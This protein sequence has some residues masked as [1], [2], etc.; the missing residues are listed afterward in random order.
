MIFR[1]ASYNHPDNE[2]MVTFFGASTIYNARGR[3]QLLRKRMVIEGEI[4]AA[5]PTAISDRMVE[6]NDAYIVSG[7][8]ALLLS[9][10]G[11][12]AYSLPSSGSISGVRVVQPP[13]FI[14]QEGKAHMATGLPFSVVLE[15]DYQINDGD[16][17]VS[18]EETITH[19]G[20]GGPRRV[21]LELDSGQPIEQIV[22]SFTPVTV[23]QA[24]EA[25]GS[26]SYPNVNQ[27]IFPS[28]VDLPDGL[29]IS[30]SAPRLDGNTYVDWPIRWAYRMALTSL[31]TIP[32]PLLR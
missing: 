9:D 28:Q 30:T 26:L 10:E 29:Q 25:V 16:T 20:N 21:T 15:A 13:S 3:P 24:G 17:L 7:G 1:Y 6:I 14:Q 2:C 12:T 32:Y 19:V 8:S 18:Y 31:G 27:P 22:S 11:G 4:I 5:G 23:I